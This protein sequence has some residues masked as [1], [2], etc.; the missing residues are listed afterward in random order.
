M[1]IA[2]LK[3]VVLAHAGTPFLHALPD[4]SRERGPRVR[5]ESLPHKGNDGVNRN[6]VRSF[7]V[8]P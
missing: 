6:A 5:E 7:G 1:T 3:T 4:S 8:P 2:I